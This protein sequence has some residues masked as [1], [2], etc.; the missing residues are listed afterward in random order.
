MQSLL[1]EFSVEHSILS[2]NE[3]A[4]IVYLGKPLIYYNSTENEILL[5]KKNLTLAK[6]N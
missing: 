1:Y 6:H 4:N 5:K 3:N 2:I